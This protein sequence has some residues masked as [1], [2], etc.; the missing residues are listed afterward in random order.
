MPRSTKCVF[1]SGFPT[2]IFYLFVLLSLIDLSIID[3]VCIYLTLLQLEVSEYERTTDIIFRI[4]YT[5][6]EIEVRF[7]IVF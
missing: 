3:V 2:E 5:L 4:I 7:S 1:F 6:A